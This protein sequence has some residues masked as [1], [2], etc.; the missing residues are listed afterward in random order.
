MRGELA[1]GRKTTIRMG[2]Y[3]HVSSYMSHTSGTLTGV[4]TRLDMLDVE[5]WLHESKPGARSCT[6]SA[7]RTHT[8]GNASATIWS[9]VACGSLMKA[10]TATEIRIEFVGDSGKSPSGM[11][12]RSSSKLRK[13]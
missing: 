5:V 11:S 6:A 9:T 12:A 13:S 2:Y 7:T 4:N 1:D 10:Y 8:W 3:P